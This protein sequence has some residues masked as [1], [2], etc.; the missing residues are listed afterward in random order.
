V[1]IIAQSICK[2]RAKGFET[3]KVCIKSSA[4]ISNSDTRFYLE[5]MNQNKER[6]ITKLKG[7]N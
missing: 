6:E 2:A 7:N 3:G 1:T 4:T 5:S